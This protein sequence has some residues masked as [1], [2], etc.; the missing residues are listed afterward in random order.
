MFRYVDKEKAFTLIE[1]LI[2]V[3]IIGILAAIAIP[4]F[5][6]AQTRA[7]VARAK[8]DMTSIATAQEMY[9]VDNNVYAYP[10]VSFGASPVVNWLRVDGFLSPLLTTPVAYMTSLHID[11]FAL[12]YFGGGGQGRINVPLGHEYTRYRMMI[13][14]PIGDWPGVPSDSRNWEYIYNSVLDLINASRNTQYLITS[15][16]PDQTEDTIF[17]YHPTTYD[18]TN[19]TISSGD[20]TRVAGGGYH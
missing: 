20:I 3:A 12:Q 9:Y 10:M 13:K 17:P 19:G 15:V 11:Q 16:G 7:K 1:L 6:E 2:V 4:N 14:E 5:M 8:A 18:P